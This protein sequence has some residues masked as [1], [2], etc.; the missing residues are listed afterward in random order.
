M[1]KAKVYSLVA[2]LSLA[3]TVIFFLSYL[4]LIYP[5][6]KL[7]VNHSVYQVLLPSGGSANSLGVA[8]QEKGVIKSRLFF[9]LWLSLSGYSTRQL[10][11]GEYIITPGMTVRE[12]IGKIEHGEVVYH[13]FSIIDGWSLSRVLKELE[14][15]PYLVHKIK[16]MSPRKLAKAVS[17]KKHANLEGLLLPETYFYTYGDTD[18]SVLEHAYETMQKFLQKEWKGR[19]KK[20][21]YKSVYTAIV[22]ASLIEKE[23]SVEE[24]R[25]IVASVILNRLKKRMRLQIDPTI[26]YALGEKFKGDLTDKNMKVK[27]PYNTYLNYGLPPTPIAM[28]GKTSIVA[29]LHPTKS[30]YLYFV[31]NGDG[32]HVFST[33]Y[34]R[35][36]KFVDAL[37]ET[38]DKKK[39]EK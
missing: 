25:P 10:R 3:V 9:S 36:R 27:S 37:G 23:T 18:V 8:L 24:E 38:F 12:L 30:P 19:Q 39:E 4:F 11:S 33:T 32:G 16:K 2:F 28:P 1:R 5:N 7:S 17:E 31:A 14:D 15:T 20:L 35:H 26:I 13:R 22:L 21:P 34:Q 6:Q 29:A